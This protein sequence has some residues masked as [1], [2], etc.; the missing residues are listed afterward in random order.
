MSQIILSRA[1]GESRVQIIVGYDTPFDT[2]SLFVERHGEPL[3]ADAFA[4]LDALQRAARAI[5]LVLHAAVLDQLTRDRRTQCEDRR[6][7]SDVW[8]HHVAPREP[9]VQVLEPAA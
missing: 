6:D 3:F 8:A 9:L 2:F 7:W 1:R 4:R 5:G